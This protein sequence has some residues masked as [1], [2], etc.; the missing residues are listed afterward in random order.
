MNTEIVTKTT[1]KAEITRTKREIEDNPITIKVRVIS[2]T[3]T[4]IHNRMMAKTNSST[5]KRIKFNKKVLKPK[6]K[7]TV[8]LKQKVI[9]K[10]SPKNNHFYNNNLKNTRRNLTHL[11]MKKKLRNQPIYLII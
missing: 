9:R 4:T 11:K 3:K 10:M 5:N 8:I 2:L 1:V 6:N 7:K